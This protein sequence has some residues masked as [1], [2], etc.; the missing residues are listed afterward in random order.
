M[1]LF[2]CSLNK[3]TKPAPEVR[4]VDVEEVENK[5]DL[6]IDKDKT[7]EEIIVSLFAEKFE[8]EEGDISL[9]EVTIADNHASGMVIIGEGGPGGAGGFLASN[10]K[11]DWEIVWEGNGVIGCEEVEGYDFPGDMMGSCV[12]A[13]G[14]W[15]VYNEDLL[16]QLI[17]EKFIQEPGFESYT[18]EDITI[19]IS[20]RDDTHV[21]GM[22]TF[23]EG[24]PGNAG[25]FL[26]ANTM[27]GWV[28][29]WHGNGVYMCADLVPYN[30]PASMSEGCYNG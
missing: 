23:G 14:L 2:G 4:D 8:M 18:L 16:K 27:A 3:K 15:L 19:D 30:F 6:V 24:G 17:K 26:A 9:Q 11:G 22:V 28:L 29:V 1:T 5:D 21:K 20:E 12:D 7:V 10:I 25:G 13:D